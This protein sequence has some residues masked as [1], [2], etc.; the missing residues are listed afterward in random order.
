MYPNEIL[1]TTCELKVYD[2]HFQ[3]ESSY[4]CDRRRTS[5]SQSIQQYPV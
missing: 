4:P 5:V 3:N 1:Q 2:D